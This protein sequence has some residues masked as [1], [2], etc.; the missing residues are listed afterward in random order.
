MV[1][2]ECDRCNG[3]MVARPSNQVKV[4]G[5]PAKSNV[6]LDLCDEC[7]KEVFKWTR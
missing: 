3:R 6:A 7:F 5:G 2:Y 4:V 1:V